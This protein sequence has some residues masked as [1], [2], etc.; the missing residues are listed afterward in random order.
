MHHQ[1]N[2][3]SAKNDRD[4]YRQSIIQNDLLNRKAENIRKLVLE[5]IRK[6]QED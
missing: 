6:I 1:V 3:F 2:A 5:T 4:I